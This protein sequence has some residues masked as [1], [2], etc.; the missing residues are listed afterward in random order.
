MGELYQSFHSLFTFQSKGSWNS[1]S[2][3]SITKIAFHSVLYRSNHD[4]F[5]RIFTSFISDFVAI[6]C[7]WKSYKY[8]KRFLNL[9]AIINMDFTFNNVCCGCDFI[10]KLSCICYDLIQTHYSSEG[11]ICIIT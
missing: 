1:K 6:T 7:F 11:Q 3:R 10:R 2:R 8:S 4:K 5:I 9:A